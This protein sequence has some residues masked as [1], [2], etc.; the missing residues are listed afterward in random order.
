MAMLLQLTQL[1]TQWH[2]AWC[3]GSESG[4]RMLLDSLITAKFLWSVWVHCLPPRLHQQKSAMIQVTVKTLSCLTG[5][6]LPHKHFKSTSTLCT[7]TTDMELTSQKSTKA[8]AQSTL[9]IIW[10]QVLLTRSTW[11]QQTSTVSQHDH[12]FH[13]LNLASRPTM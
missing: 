7:W 2:R 12:P 1:S 5:V 8:C 6:H 10:L 3:I 11:P 9:W 4:L 13:S